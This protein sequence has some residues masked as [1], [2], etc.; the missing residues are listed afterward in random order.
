MLV[1]GYHA[2]DS[3]LVL[4]QIRS[5]IEDECTKISKGFASKDSVVKKAIE[6]FSGKFDFFVKNINKMD[7]LFG[8]SFSKLE[9]IGKPF[10]RCGLSRRYLQY[11]PGPPPR[12]YNKYTETVYALPVGGFVKQWTGRTC[13]VEG[14]NFELCLYSVGQPQR[15]FPLC[16][17]CFN[18]PDWALVSDDMPEDTVERQDKAKE[19]QIKTVAGKMLTLECPLPDNHPLIDELTV[20]PDPE[21]DGVLILDP[22]FGP[23][24]R[25]V[26]TRGMRVCL[27]GCCCCLTGLLLLLLLLLSANSFLSAPN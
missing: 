6:L 13:P 21:T 3:S 19:K 8:S 23:K 2:I 9:D 17:Y 10:T 11:I 12:L 22:H 15:T 26:A 4:P 14:C 7:M 1:N 25:L 27:P 18:H 16:P 5:D 20:S 24:W